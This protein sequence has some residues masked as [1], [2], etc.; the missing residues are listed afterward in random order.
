MFSFENIYRA[1]KDCIKHKRNTLNALNFEANLLENI[2]NLEEELKNKGI[3]AI[4]RAKV[5]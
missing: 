5:L 2:C 4:K 3:G 1:Y